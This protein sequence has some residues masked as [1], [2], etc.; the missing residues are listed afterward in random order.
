MAV[1]RSIEEAQP[2]LAAHERCRRVAE[3]LRLGP[4]FAINL[5]VV[6][7]AARRARCGSAGELRYAP[8]V[9]EAADRRVVARLLGEIPTLGSVGVLEAAAKVFAEDGVVRL[10]ADRQH[11]WT[12]LVVDQTFF[13]PGVRTVAG[14]AR[15]PGAADRQLTV[16]SREKVAQDIDEALLR[17]VFRARPVRR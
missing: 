13:T 1:F 7:W 15:D 9:G 12:M 6:L 8:V 16:P 10:G 5:E 14:S 3:E 2:A 4:Q 17:V 11:A